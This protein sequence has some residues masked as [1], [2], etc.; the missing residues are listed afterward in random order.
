MLATSIIVF[1]EVLEAALIISIVLA[2]TRL[3]P[4]SRPWAAFGI[5]GG[6]I[7]AVARSEERRV[8]KECA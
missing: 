7:G 2:A 6:L 8:G 4:G 1:R 3:L 5:A